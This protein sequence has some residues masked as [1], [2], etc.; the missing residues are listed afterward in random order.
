MSRLFSGDEHNRQIRHLASHF[1]VSED[2]YLSLNFDR[3]IIRRLRTE[4]VQ[5]TPQATETG[6]MMDC[7]FMDRNINNFRSVEDAYHQFIIDLIAQQIASIK[8]TFDHQINRKIMV[9]GGLAKNPIFMELLA[10]AF[11]DKVVYTIG[12]EHTAALGAASVIAS[13]WGADLSAITADM[14]QL[15][16]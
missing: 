11:H 14:L 10:E 16:Y 7:P 3:N 8:L 9:D 13:S 4:F 15:K 6:G 12:Y 1:H 5:V 2:F